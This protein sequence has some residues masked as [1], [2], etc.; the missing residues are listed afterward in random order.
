MEKKNKRLTDLRGFEK[1]LSAFVKKYFHNFTLRKKSSNFD[2]NEFQSVVEKIKCLKKRAILKFAY[3]CC[4]FHLSLKTFLFIIKSEHVLT[5]N[6]FAFL[7]NRT[8]EEDLEFQSPAGIN[9]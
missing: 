3:Q 5:L 8:V 4:F 9:L 1:G 2:K 6:S 7:I